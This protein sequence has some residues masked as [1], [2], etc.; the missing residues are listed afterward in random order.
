VISRRDL[1]L[2]AVAASSAAMATRVLSS[3]PAGADPF[4][5]PAPRWSDPATWGGQV[6][7]AGAN[8]MLPATTVLLDVD[9][10]VGELVIPEGATLLFDPTASRTLSATGNVVVNGTLAMRPNNSTVVHTCRFVGVNEAS[11]VGGGMVPVA[12]D[13]G[14]WVTMN[15][16]LDA[17][18]TAKTSWARLAAD[19]PVGAQTI[20]LAAPPVGWQVGDVVTIV[21]TLRG[22]VDQ[23]DERTITAVNGPVVSLSSPTT[24]AH[25]LVQLEP[26]FVLGGEVLNLTRNVNIEGTATG[27]AHVFVLSS[28]RQT[29]A[30]VALRHLGPRKPTGEIAFPSGV[31]TPITAGVTGRYPL[32]WHMMGD[33]SRGST[34]TGVLAH[35]CGNHAF[36]TH[37]SHGVTYTGCVAHDIFDDAYWWDPPPA[38]TNDTTY[39][40][41]VASRLRCDPAFRGFRLTGFQMAAGTGNRCLDCVAVGNLGN[42]NAAGFQWPEM[43]TPAANVSLWEFRRN[44]AHNGVAAGIFTWQNTTGAHLVEDFVC[45]HNGV[46]GIQHGAYLNNYTYRNGW[47]VGNGRGV[48]LHS[49]GGT[50]FE[51]ILIDGANI[52]N[53][54]P[55]AGFR[56]QLAG[57]A[58][59]VRGCEFANHPGSY[60]F[61]PESTGQADA[62]DFVECSPVTPTFA[63]NAAPTSMVRI[64]NGATANQHTPSAVTSIAPFSTWTSTPRVPF[65]PVAGA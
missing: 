41:C 6:P 61:A 36:V 15:G 52:P 25:P 58:N 64:Q 57:V 46:A 12:T 29:I 55:V 2:G 32:H 33:A 11:Y 45:Y 50:A 49:L 47:L 56:H 31:P 27:R 7:S 21:P 8:V 10:Q 5:L 37:Q 54:R 65:T 44:I 53:G 30:H 13:V 24:F 43:P 63:A 34:V 59:V 1:I 26:G 20:V 28:Q 48:E 9:A 60:H 4:C 18:G 51:R 3:V 17:V 14:L 19:V 38:T 23:Y 16:V 42:K 62:V 22:H 35:L 40:S 39:Q